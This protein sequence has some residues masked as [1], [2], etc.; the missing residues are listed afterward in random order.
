ML[1]ARALVSAAET[2]SFASVPRVRSLTNGTVSAANLSP[3]GIGGGEGAGGGAGTAAF[4][5]AVAAG[6]TDGEGVGAAS[7]LTEDE[8]FGPPGISS[9]ARYRKPPTPIATRQTTITASG[10]IQFG[11][12]AAPTGF[13]F[14]FGLEYVPSSRRIA[15]M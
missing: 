6:A 5:A 7:L 8:L 4:G 13:F 2:Y 1:R 3:K 9:L 15:T 12:A 14:N 11:V 10:H